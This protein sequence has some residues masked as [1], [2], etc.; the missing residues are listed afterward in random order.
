MRFETLGKGSLDCVVG[1]Y[2]P[3]SG[4]RWWTQ[5]VSFTAL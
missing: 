5:I 2:Y 4:Q 3:V 1:F